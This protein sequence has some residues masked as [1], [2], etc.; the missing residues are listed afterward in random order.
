M[1]HT[2]HTHTLVARSTILNVCSLFIYDGT[3]S[4]TSVLVL[5]LIYIADCSTSLHF[6][7]NIGVGI[8]PLLPN[9]LPINPSSSTNLF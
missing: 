2:L 8:P 4:R 6:H 5:V 3:S 9:K 1:R 7:F